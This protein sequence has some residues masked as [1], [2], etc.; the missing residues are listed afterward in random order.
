MKTIKIKKYWF[1]SAGAK[2]GWVKEGMDCK[3]VGILMEIL[4]T[5]KCLKI[6]IVGQE[7]LLDSCD[8]AL[9]FIEKYKSIFIAG[10]STEVGVISRSLLRQIGGSESDEKKE[11]DEEVSQ[12]RHSDPDQ[13]KDEEEDMG[14]EKAN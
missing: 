3:G 13:Q 12:M 9:A 7:Y 10:G 11:E 1:V 6:E 8:K 4:R 14:L 2:Y 5:N